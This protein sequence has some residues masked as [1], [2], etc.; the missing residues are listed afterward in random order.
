MAIGI[1]D[2]ELHEIRRVFNNFDK[3]GSGA[4][5]FDEVNEAFNTLHKDYSENRIGQVL[6][7]I[8]LN[9]DGYIT[10]HEFLSLYKRLKQK[11]RQEQK[12]RKAFEIC[13]KDNSGHICLNELQRVME[14]VGGE[15][16]E[17][18][19]KQMLKKADIN[20]DTMIDYKEFIQLLKEN[21]ILI[22]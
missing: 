14:Q 8:D 21:G 19:L 13:D 11:E 17:L 1:E 3:D 6:A 22:D 4:I 2:E 20:G 5:T 10:F 12:I 18:E 15:L 7:Q 16:N 9:Q